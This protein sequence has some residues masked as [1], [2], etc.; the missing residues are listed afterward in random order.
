[1]NM[2][3]SDTM[4]LLKHINK[5]T[6]LIPFEK[7][8]IQ[9]YHHHRQLIPEQQIGEHNPIYQLIHDLHNMSRFTRLTD[10]YSNINVT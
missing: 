4:T 9:P 6:L 1:M 5:T 7:L 8:Y 10:Q 2:A 3:L